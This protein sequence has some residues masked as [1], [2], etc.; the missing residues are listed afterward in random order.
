MRGVV[1]VVVLQQAGEIFPGLWSEKT[2]EAGLLSVPPL[3][4]IRALRFCCFAALSHKM[5]FSIDKTSNEI[6]NILIFASFDYTTSFHWR[7]RPDLNVAH[8]HRQVDTTQTLMCCLLLF[9]T[10]DY[11]DLSD[12]IRNGNK[13]SFMKIR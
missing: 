11:C 12:H 8:T 6:V 3:V 10:R 13:N 2:E 7:S 9:F 1:D 5:H 4:V